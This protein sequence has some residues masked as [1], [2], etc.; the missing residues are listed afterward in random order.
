MCG[1]AMDRLS[2]LAANSVQCCVTSPPYFNLRDYGAPGQLGRE[3]SPKEYVEKLVNVFR[4]VR[5]VLRPDSTLWLNLGDSCT[6]GNR[7]NKRDV[8]TISTSS[9]KG[10]HF[11]V[12]P[13]KL[14]EP[15]ILAGCPKDGRV[16]DPFMGSGTRAWWPIG[17]C[18]ASSARH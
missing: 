1:D 12:F 10:A 15:C 7:K 17:W 18:G 4:E 2:A 9:F 13:E 11:A 3:T 14:A 5:R 16:L 6:S 8:W